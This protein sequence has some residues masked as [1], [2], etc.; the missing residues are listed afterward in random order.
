MLRQ[1]VVV[2]THPDDHSV[3]LV[4]VDDGS[5]VIGA[6]VMSWNGSSR[7]GKIDLPSVDQ[8]LNKWD[9]TK[10]GDQEVIAMVGYVG[11]QPVVL[12]FRYPQ[13]SQ[14]TFSDPKFRIDRHQ[15]DVYSSIDGDGN[16]ELHHPGG[17]YIR[18]GEQP[19]H[20]DLSSKNA[21]ASFAL[22]RNTG[23]K[24]YLRVE[25]AGNVARLTLSPDGECTLTLDKSFDLHAKEDIKLKADGDVSIEAAGKVDIKAGD[26]IKTESVGNTTIHAP[27]ITEQGN[28]STTGSLDV[29]GDTSVKSITSNGKNISDSHYHH[30]SGGP[31]DGGQVA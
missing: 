15:S 29:Q 1:G 6:Q 4:M 5:R 3:D 2:A 7:S 19:D 24:V 21:D 20:V 31:G 10:R 16:I 22:D 9:I 25:L 11:R 8:K 23:R 13:I 27:T 28:V 14:M 17:A 30:N 18:F 12:G 26:T